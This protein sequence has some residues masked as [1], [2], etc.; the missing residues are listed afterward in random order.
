MVSS[1]FINY[2]LLGNESSCDWLYWLVDCDS[3]YGFWHIVTNPI[4]S[5]IYIYVYIYIYIWVC[6]CMCSQLLRSKALKP[7]PGWTNW[8]PIYSTSILN[9]SWLSR[10]PPPSIRPSTNGGSFRW[11]GAVSNG[12]EKVGQNTIV[13]HHGSNK[14]LQV[15]RSQLTPLMNRERPVNSAQEAGW[16]RGSKTK[17]CVTL[18]LQPNDKQRETRFYHINMICSFWRPIFRFTL[19]VRRLVIWYVK[20]RWWHCG[21]CQL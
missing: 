12:C 9:G 18:R 6:V 20:T 8:T 16:S 1:G 10:F 13:H 5:V 3:Q 17:H 4:R 19:S 15:C 21:S 2:K 7:I 11:S 14:K